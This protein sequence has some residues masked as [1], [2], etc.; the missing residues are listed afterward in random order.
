MIKE[1]VSDADNPLNTE[2]CYKAF[3]VANAGYSECQ[4]QML[5]VMLYL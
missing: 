1:P 4:Q 3:Y 5:N 2:M